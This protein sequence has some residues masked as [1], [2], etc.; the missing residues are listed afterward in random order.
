MVTDLLLEIAAGLR[1]SYSRSTG[2]AYAEWL[3]IAPEEKRIWID[4][5]R[6][7]MR[8]MASAL[9]A[10]AEAIISGADRE[11]DPFGRER[12]N[13]SV[14]ASTISVTLGVTRR[15]ISRYVS[16][17]IPHSRTPG[18]QL[19]FNIEEVERWMTR[20]KSDSALGERHLSPQ[21]IR[22]AEA[23]GRE[24]AMLTRESDK[25]RAAKKTAKASK[26][27]P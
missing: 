2:T 23:R 6:D 5:A 19:R 20:P 15:T 25:Q 13:R 22:A 8:R 9:Q 11:V 18:G 27:E 10:S 24:I 17:G 7:A 26:M 1:W 14:P 16:D 3:R 4:M 21:S 12:V